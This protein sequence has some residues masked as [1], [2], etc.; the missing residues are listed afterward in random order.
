M[1]NDDKRDLCDAVRKFGSEHNERIALSCEC[2]IATV[3]K[4]RKAIPGAKP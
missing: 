2:T 4:Y 1:T 3:K